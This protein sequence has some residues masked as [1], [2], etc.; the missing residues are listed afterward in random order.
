[1]T[2]LGKSGN[3]PMRPQDMLG[4]DVNITAEEV[5]NDPWAHKMLR[6]VGKTMTESGYDYMGS[7]TVHMYKTTALQH[8]DGTYGCAFKTQ[9]DLG[10]TN[11]FIVMTGVSNLALEVRKRF[12]RSHK[13]TDQRDKR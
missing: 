13:T 12:G 7:I 11:E 9:L 10:D 5:E 2:Q 3:K 6:E 4:Q 8:S 1:M